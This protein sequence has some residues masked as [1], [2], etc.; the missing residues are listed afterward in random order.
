MDHS[1]ADDA[2]GGWNGL[3]PFPRIQGA[4]AAGRIAAVDSFLKHILPQDG[5][6]AV[7]FGGSSFSAVFAGGGQRP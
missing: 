2:P 1:V 5:F 3:L 6:D 7:C 4:D